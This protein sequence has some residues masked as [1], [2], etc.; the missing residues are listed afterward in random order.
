MKDEETY[1]KKEKSVFNAALAQLVRIHKLK[2]DIID[3]RTEGKIQQWVT[4]LF[5]LREELNPCISGEEKKKCDE[6]D[7]KLDDIEP[8]LIGK[9]ITNFDDI[10]PIK[11]YQRYLYG[12]EERLGLAHQSAEDE[13]ADDEDW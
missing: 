1:T 4:N 5:C 10:T 12:I 3:N 6:F 7:K 13:W 2:Q 8:S 9:R 11:Q